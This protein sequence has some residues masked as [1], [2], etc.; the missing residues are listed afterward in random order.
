MVDFD[1]HNLSFCVYLQFTKVHLKKVILHANIITIKQSS[2]I[3]F[4][5]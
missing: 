5:E 3:L 1:Q 4:G 2:E